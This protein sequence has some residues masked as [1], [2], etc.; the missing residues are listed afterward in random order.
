VERPTHIW[1]D[2]E[3]K[4]IYPGDEAIVT[5]DKFRCLA[6]LLKTGE[7]MAVY[8]NWPLKNVQEVVQVFPHLSSRAGPAPLKK[9]AAISGQRAV[10]ACSNFGEFDTIITP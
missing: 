5:T 1:K 3:G 6:R 8:G 9:P 7:W 4:G 2:Q 10:Q